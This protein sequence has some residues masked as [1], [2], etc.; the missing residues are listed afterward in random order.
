MERATQ[1]FIVVVFL[2]NLF[3]VMVFGQC[4]FW[5]TVKANSAIT[6]SPNVFQWA[7]ARQCGCRQFADYMGK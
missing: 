7:K 4:L 2:I 6:P 5:E 3:I 1:L